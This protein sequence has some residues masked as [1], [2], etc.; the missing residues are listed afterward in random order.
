MRHGQTRDT[1]LARRLRSPSDS[2]FAQGRRLGAYN[3]EQDPLPSS[4]IS[5]LAQAVYSSL[6]SYPSHGSVAM[7]FAP[8]DSQFTHAALAACLDLELYRQSPR[9]STLRRRRRRSSR[10]GARS[11]PSRPASNSPRAVPSST[12]TTARRSRPV[13]RITGTY[14]RG[15]SRCVV[16]CIILCLMSITC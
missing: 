16:P 9:R 11:T 1:R 13:C 15:R 14:W 12:S 7:S 6:T 2:S 3:N 5:H 10:S 4:H 8:H